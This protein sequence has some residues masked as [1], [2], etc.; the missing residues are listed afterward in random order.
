MSPLNFGSLK[1]RK[2][3]TA[4]FLT[5]VVL[6]GA[7]LYAPYWIKGRMESIT[8]ERTSYRV[9]IGDIDLAIWRGAYL[10]ESVSMVERS[11]SRYGDRLRIGKVDISVEWGELI[12]G[13]LVG[14][15]SLSDVHWAHDTAEGDED[16]DS[17]E[18]DWRAVVRDLMPIRINRFELK[19]GEFMI[20][21]KGSGRE[22]DLVFNDI[23]L[24][25]TNISNVSDSG[26]DLPSEYT[27]RAVF[28]T[29][30]PFY[31]TGRI[32][33]LSERLS[34]SGGLVSEEITLNEINELAR[35][36][37]GL[38][39]E[40][41]RLKLFSQWTVD[42]DSLGGFVKFLGYDLKVMEWE[43]D[44][45]NPIEFVWEG[46]AGLFVQLVE[47]QKRDQF[48]S[49]IPLEGDISDPDFK[50]IPTLVGLLENG[51]VKALEPGLE[52]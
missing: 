17:A 41:G 39:F 23:D 3:L 14:E 10:I 1:K 38:D 26:E 4:L 44:A 46:I 37:A 13:H 21:R 22:M 25:A 5:A 40:S 30:V 7:R 15:L 50:V 48:A 45:S 12:R 31:A 8:E 35:S 52:P 43:D 18:F 9:E 32:D 6:L 29:G 36:Y 51:F 11:E 47:N 33:L 16:G 27:V 2:V 20:L 28:A 49:E 42:D 19:N 34:M 24:L